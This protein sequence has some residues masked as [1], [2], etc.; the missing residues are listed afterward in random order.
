MRLT[1]HFSPRNAPLG[2]RL[3]ITLNSLNSTQRVEII[4]LSARKHKE[5]ERMGGGMEQTNGQILS[6][7]FSPYIMIKKWTWSMTLHNVFY[8]F[9]NV[10]SQISLPM[11]GT[12]TPQSPDSNPLEHAKTFFNLKYD[13]GNKHAKL[14]YKN[15]E[16]SSTSS[17]TF[18]L[19]RKLNR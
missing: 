11:C 5:D 13:H 18:F 4:L 17:K 10:F 14:R 16:V 3:K 2:I 12:L 8:L 9:S 7:I 1:K 19:M 15:I 6:F